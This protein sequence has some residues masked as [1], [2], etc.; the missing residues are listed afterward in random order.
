MFIWAAWAVEAISSSALIFY[1]DLFQYDLSHSSV[2][3]VAPKTVKDPDHCAK[4]AKADYSS[5]H[6]HPNEIGVIQL[7]C[8]GTVWEP[9][10]EMSSHATCQG[11]LSLLSLNW[12]MC[13]AISTLKKKMQAGMEWF[14]KYSPNYPLMPRKDTKVTQ[15]GVPCKMFGLS[16]FNFKAI[17]NCSNKSCTHTHT[18]KK[19]TYCPYLLTCLT[20]CTQIW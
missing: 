12:H 19:K 9:I 5:T 3:T 6:K 20:L 18:P 7:P 2:T 4:N 10:R 1:A 14:I 11:M 17:Y 16:V 13:K 8:P 15:A